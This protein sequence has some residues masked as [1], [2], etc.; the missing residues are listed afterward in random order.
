MK[1]A[2]FPPLQFPVNF[3]AVLF[4]CQGAA[5]FDRNFPALCEAVS[6]RHRSRPPASRTA[7]LSELKEVSSDDANEQDPA[8]KNQACADET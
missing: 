5:R 2:A 4:H 6:A 1:V 8:Q 3:P 7:A